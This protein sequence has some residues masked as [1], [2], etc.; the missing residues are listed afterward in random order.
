MVDRGYCR[1][2]SSLELL[3]AAISEHRIH[4]GQAIDGEEDRERLTGDKDGRQ[5]G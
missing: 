5:G 4:C 1:P 3:I 2:K